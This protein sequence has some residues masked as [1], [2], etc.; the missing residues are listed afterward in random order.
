M[1]KIMILLTMTLMLLFGC[2]QAAYH[3]EPSIL[4]SI[5]ITSLPKKMIYN[6][7]EYFSSKG[8]SVKAVYSDGKNQENFLFTTMPSDGARLMNEGE[9]EIT[10]LAGTLTKKI[11]IQVNMKVITSVEI[12]KMPNKVNYI[13]GELFDSAGLEVTAHYSDDT[14]SVLNANQY[15]VTPENGEELAEIKKVPVMVAVPGY[16]DTDYIFVSG[17]TN[18]EGDPPVE[19]PEEPDAE[20]TEQ[21]LLYY[22]EDGN[23]IINGLASNCTARHISIPEKIGDYSV[24]EIRPI[25]EEDYPQTDFSAA[26]S[27][28]VPGSVKT[29]GEEAFSSCSALKKIVVKDGCK[30]IEEDAF[31][32]LPYLETLELPDSIEEVEKWSFRNLDKLKEI[33]LNAASIKTDTILNC[34]SLE[35][36][37]LT[38]PN[39]RIAE[40]AFCE[41]PS[42][43]NVN[44]ASLE[45][46]MTDD[47]MNFGPE[48]YFGYCGSFNVKYT[49]TESRVGAYVFA[50]DNIESFKQ[51]K[52]VIKT[53]GINSFEGAT[54]HEMPETVEVVEDY[55]YKKA[56]CDKLLLPEC[57]RIIGTEAFAGSTIDTLTLG[58]NITYLGLGIFGG[59]DLENLIIG[60]NVPDNSY[61]SFDTTSYIN[62]SSVYDKTEYEF[63]TELNLS[64]TDDVTKI[65]ANSFKSTRIKNIKF[66]KNLQ[67]IG[68]E[69]F[70][71]WGWEERKVENLDCPSLKKLAVNSL[72]PIKNCVIYSGMESCAET[73]E[74]VD[75]L[76]LKG[77]LPDM[78][79]II[80]P[81]ELII[82]DDV[83]EYPNL[84]WNYENGEVVAFLY[85]RN[86]KKIILGKNLPKEIENER[87]TSLVALE[88][89]VFNEE[90]LPTSI[91][92]GAF[93]D[94]ANLKEITIPQG[95]KVIEDGT[96]YGCESLEKVILPEGLT[97]IAIS[98]F[99]EC[100]A[101]KQ[102]EI[103]DTV[104]TLGSWAFM[105]SGLESF[106]IPAGVT[107]ISVQTF[108]GCYNLSELNVHDNITHIGRQAFAYTKISKFPFTNK[109]EL[110]YHNAFQGTAFEEVR[111]ENLASDIVVGEGVFAD[112]EKLKSVYFAVPPEMK[113]TCIVDGEE[114][115]ISA[116]AYMFENC[117]ALEKIEFA[118]D[119]S[120]IPYNFLKNCKSLTELTIPAGCKVDIYGFAD[121]CLNL[122]KIVYEG[123]VIPGFHWPT[124]QR[125]EEIVVKST[126]NW[127]EVIPEFWHSKVT[128]M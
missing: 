126:S 83:T 34:A 70:I 25:M 52:S 73:F 61:T 119:I 125:F 51:E 7:G 69:A 31:S 12:T 88:E 96:F 19:E 113:N 128:E 115:T 118:S 45:D 74:K 32:F 46:C 92:K 44:I 108:G 112:C 97:S 84:S 13:Q 54:I 2:E 120:E 50:G 75:V 60:Y 116:Y 17:V 124:P 18:E 22:I 48:G 67:E 8:L 110:I 105:Y 111:L 37:N 104:T 109:L 64:F 85:N 107:E 114:S 66:P 5:E 58:K 65:G 71:Q 16:S 106:T 87:F 121:G 78:K 63:E 11:N 90:N 24:T 10:I 42:L 81:S 35:T 59:S 80:K 14:S 39:A 93:S 68:E 53:I 3:E 56:V 4:S 94:C 100:K 40:M 6:K 57:I 21:W 98:A 36:L 15:V 23:A 86:T 47:L 103:P 89:I 91:G 79:Q 122:K 33:T 41:L 77:H 127:K 102:I 28:T 29:I 62:N 38:N 82:G 117:T 27:V 26:I 49:G 101:L 20:D 55:A 9:Q 76:T 99:Y 123:N 43:K 1:R 72:P 30:K 95:I